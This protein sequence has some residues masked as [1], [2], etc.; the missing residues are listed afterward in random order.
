MAAQLDQQLA[1]AVGAP[2]PQVDLILADMCQAQPG[3]TFKCSIYMRDGSLAV[4]NAGPAAV[5]S[6]PQNNRNPVCQS[7]HDC[8]ELQS[9][10]VGDKCLQRVKDLSSHPCRRLGRVAGVRR[11][12]HGGGRRAPGPGRALSGW[13]G[14]AGRPAPQDRHRDHPQHRVQP[15]APHQHVSKRTQAPPLT[16][17]CDV[18]P[19][20]WYWPGQRKLVLCHQWAICLPRRI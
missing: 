6:T 17:G 15:G 4:W 1:K 2:R 20:C 16:C 11:S 12:C 8:A 19:C 7:R 9:F 10:P 14:A 13:A 5:D 3:K 18:G